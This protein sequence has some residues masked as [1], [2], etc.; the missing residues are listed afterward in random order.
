MARLSSNM[1][2]FLG[3]LAIITFL[4]P[5][6]GRHHVFTFPGGAAVMVRLA[7]PKGDAI[8]ISEFVSTMQRMGHGT[9][10]MQRL[11]ELADRHGILLTL[12][13]I[14]Y[15]Y[16]PIPT[17]KLIRFYQEHGFQVRKGGMDD[18]DLMVRRPAPK[19]SAPVSVR[20]FTQWEVAH[21]NG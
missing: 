8:H 14:P 17:G 11:V 7:G 18:E 3:E 12:H 9:T 2:S 5:L 20:S 15:G 10:A 4:N 6:S 21:G 19:H 16:N 1:A 13:A